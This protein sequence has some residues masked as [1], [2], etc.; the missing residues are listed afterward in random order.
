MEGDEFES[1][2]RAR[3]WF[4]ALTVPPGMWVVIRVDGRSFTRFTADRFG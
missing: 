2:Q 1:A 4:H 3:E